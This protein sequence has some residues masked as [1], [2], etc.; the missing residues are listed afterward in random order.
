MVVLDRLERQA[1]YQAAQTEM[2]PLRDQAR[3]LIRYG[4]VQRGFLA[5]EEASG[6]PAEGGSREGYRA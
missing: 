5:P 4:L 2:R 1:L 3:W 6:E